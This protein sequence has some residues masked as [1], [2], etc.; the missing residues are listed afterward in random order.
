VLLLGHL[1]LLSIL[2]SL[3]ELAVAVLSMVLVVV[4]VAIGHQLLEN[5]LAV[6]HPQN[7]AYCQY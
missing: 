1:H 3:V 2:L 7:H 6:V 4:L 5:H